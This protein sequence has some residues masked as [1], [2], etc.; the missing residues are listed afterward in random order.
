MKKIKLGNTDIKIT[1]IGL[2]CWQFSRGAGF[3]GKY[4]DN[5][6]TALIDEIVKI[7]LDEGI[8]WFDT[9]EVYGWGNSEKALAEALQKCGVERGK[10]VI[11]TK[12]HP[13]F[14]TAKSILNTFDKRIEALSGYPVDLH[15]IHSPFSFS[16]IRNQ[17]QAMAELLREKKIKA[18]GVSNFS[19]EQMCTADD[20]LKEEGFSLASNQVRYSLLDRKTERK[21]VFAAAKERDITIIAYSPLAQG[22]LS[23]KFHENPKLIKDR[24]G[25]RKMLSGF[26][27]K[28]LKKSEPLINMLRELAK[29]YKVTPAQVAL[30]WT[31]HFH[32]DFVVAIPGATSAE[33]ARDNAR[34]LSFKLKKTELEGLD[35][36]SRSI[37]QME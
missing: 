4:W 26:K 25:P 27:E 1:P 6:E 12:W 17:M 37:K 23:G 7:S 2:G 8:N 24:P 20:V 21:E 18:V 19:A 33:Q 14:R 34:A 15:Q 29:N 22:I 28:G 16:S 5:L 36:I 30:N 3:A 31:V 10:V 11:A 9:A 35:A 32:G 13:V